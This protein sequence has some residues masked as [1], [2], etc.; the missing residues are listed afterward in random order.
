[1]GKAVIKGTGNSAEAV[2]SKVKEVVLGTE[3]IMELLDGLEV[4]IDFAAKILADGRV[5]FND[6]KE[7]QLFITK[8]DVLKDAVTGLDH[9]LKEAKDVDQAEFMAIMLKLVTMFK[10]VKAIRV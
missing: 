3:E 9:V 5:G 6:I 2:E 8:Y 10:K 1:M 4:L 7:A